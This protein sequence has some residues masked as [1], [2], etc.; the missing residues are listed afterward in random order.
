[1]KQWIEQEYEVTLLNG[2]SGIHLRGATVITPSPTCCAQRMS[3]RRKYRHYFPAL[4]LGSSE[5]MQDSVT[6][7]SHFQL[8]SLGWTYVSLHLHTGAAE[9]SIDMVFIVTHS[10][11]ASN[12]IPL[13]LINETKL[14]HI[15]FGCW[16]I[17]TFKPVTLQWCSKW[18]DLFCI[19][20]QYSLHA[21]HTWDIN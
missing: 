5:W 11:G 1:M 19:L 6:V 17:K 2:G 7:K 8:I 10:N 15:F 20:Q 9:T 14:H 21:F 13:I 18:A 3:T 12:T 4:V 16:Q